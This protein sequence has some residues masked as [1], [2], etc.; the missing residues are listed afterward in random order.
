VDTSKDLFAGTSYNGVFISTDG[1]SFWSQTGVSSPFIFYSVIT[2]AID[3]EGRI[4]AGTDTSGAYSS[5]DLGVNWNRIPSISGKGVTCFLVNNPTMYFA[6]TS[7]SGAFAS[8]DR[9]WSWHSVNNGLTE[10]STMSLDVD[11]QEHLY[12][13]TS[14]GLFKSTGIVTR[15]DEKGRV[16]SS[17]SLFQNYPNP[18]NPTTVINYQLS[19]NSEVTLKIYDVLGRLVNT[20]IEERQT[21]GARSVAF[22]ASNLSSGIYFYRLAAGSYVET[23]KMILI[24]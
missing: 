10:S 3:S 22:N 23:K 18:F 9:G 1:G 15:I 6:G 19:V 8:T 2:M 14:K 21:A 17:F 16:P 24:K 4:F 5:D 20:L 13:G 12:A 11:Q 7:D